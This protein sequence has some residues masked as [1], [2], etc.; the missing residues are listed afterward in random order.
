M[1]HCTCGCPTID[2][3]IDGATE[4]TVGISL[5]LADFNGQTPEG[6]KVGVTL[7]AR[8]GKLS[9]LEVYSFRDEDKSFSLP[10]MESLT[11]DEQ[12]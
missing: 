6:I 12:L 8:Q 10:T 3:G 9:E 4:R 5:V 7:H 2:L 1:G 11:K